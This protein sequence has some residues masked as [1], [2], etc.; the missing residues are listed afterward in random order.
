MRAS[1][2]FFSLSVWE[3]HGSIWENYLHE[4]FFN[5]VTLLPIFNIL[6]N[7]ITFTKHFFNVQNTYK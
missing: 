7:Q 6:K 2:A 5:L 4:W 3:I 1:R